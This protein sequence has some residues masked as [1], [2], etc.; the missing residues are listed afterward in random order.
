MILRKNIPFNVQRVISEMQ[1]K[2][3]LIFNKENNIYTD[4]YTLLQ[5]QGTDFRL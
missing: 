3:I 2:P 5:T 1:E 4:L